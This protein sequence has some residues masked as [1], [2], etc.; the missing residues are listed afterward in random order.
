MGV[1]EDGTGHIPPDRGLGH[2]HG[3]PLKT[4]PETAQC[5]PTK[6]TLQ[7]RQ[8]TQGQLQQMD[9]DQRY[10]PSAWHVDPH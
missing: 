6:I 4:V 7:R 1:S 2:V 3:G 5:R 8:V 10:V 9:C